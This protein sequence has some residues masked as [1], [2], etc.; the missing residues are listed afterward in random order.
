MSGSR[1]RRH[2]I[3]SA[4]LEWFALHPE[5]EYRV[6]PVLIDEYCMARRRLSSA[7]PTGIPYAVIKGYPL[8]RLL[9]EMDKPLLEDVGEREAERLFNACIV[10]LPADDLDELDIY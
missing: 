10:S 2:A 6:R 1:R 3:L 5:R 7:V 8:T 4:D 9:F